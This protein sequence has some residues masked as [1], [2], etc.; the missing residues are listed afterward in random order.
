[1]ITVLGRANSLN[2]RKVLWLLDE[3][4][5]AYEREDWGHGFRDARSPEFLKLNPNGLVPVIND[6]GFVL[7]ESHA[8]LHYLAERHGPTR[9]LPA[10]LRARAISEQWLGWQATELNSSWVYAVMHLFRRDPNYQDPELVA[11]SIAL[12]TSRM[13]ILEARLAETGAHVAGE[14]FTLADIAIGLSVHRWQSLA[15]EKPDLPAV[16]AYAERLR[17]RPAGARYMSP[18]TP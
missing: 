10:D 9:I 6:G 8:I 15:F 7:W 2:V 14:E 13:R 17:R 12:W 5:L 1:M 4:G 3:L 11:R 18:E 16:A